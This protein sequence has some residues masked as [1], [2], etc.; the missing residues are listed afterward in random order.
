MHYYYPFLF[1]L[2]SVVAIQTAQGL[3]SWKLKPDWLP[4]NKGLSDSLS[5]NIQLSLDLSGEYECL[6]AGPVAESE[7]CLQPLVV[8]R[9]PLSWSLGA[10]YDL[11][12][13]PSSQ[14]IQS[15][16][17]KLESK[18]LSCRW[19]WRLPVR[20]LDTKLAWKRPK[21][22]LQLRHSDTTLQATAQVTVHPRIHCRLLV[23]NRDE[24]TAAAPLWTNNPRDDWWIPSV[25][26]DTQGG[27]E[28]TIHHVWRQQWFLK[29]TCR[30]TLWQQD[31]LTHVQVLL[32]GKDTTLALQGNLEEWRDTASLVLTH[33]QQMALR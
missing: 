4:F 5:N 19:A 3:P 13:F 26:L 10:C 7:A 23:K 8:T 33:Q 12:S 24:T 6:V 25:R 16:F 27:L 15:F 22:E 2:L 30:R 14:W 11:A 18:N 29:L 1:I 32:G 20:T 9:Q 17:T 31:G 21:Y 28:S